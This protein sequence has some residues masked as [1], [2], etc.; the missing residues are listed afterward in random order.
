M[1]DFLFTW[2]LWIGCAFGFAL[3]VAVTYWIIW[4][5]LIDT[6]KEWEKGKWYI[7]N[8][9]DNNIEYRSRREDSKR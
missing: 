7:I 1:F 2:Q 5:A 8:E 4:K 6:V 9:E 3:G